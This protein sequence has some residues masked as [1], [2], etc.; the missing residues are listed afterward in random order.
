MELTIHTSTKA[1]MCTQ[2][3]NHHQLSARLVWW[4]DHSHRQNLVPFGIPVHGVKLANYN[5]SI[6]LSVLNSWHVIHAKQWQKKRWSAKSGNDVDH[7]YMYMYNNIIIAENTK[8]QIH[9]FPHMLIYSQVMCLNLILIWNNI[10][11]MSWWGVYGPQTFTNINIEAEYYWT[12]QLSNEGLTVPVQFAVQIL[13][14]VHTA[15]VHKGS[16]GNTTA[17]LQRIVALFPLFWS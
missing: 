5:Y 15:E 10:I 11:H 17:I 13:I 6:V 12:L 7:L 8:A 16:I 3:S 4:I 9:T 14:I 1:Q 2:C